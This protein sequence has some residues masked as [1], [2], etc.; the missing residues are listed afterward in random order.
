MPMCSVCHQADKTIKHYLL[1]CS[2]YER[3]WREL[4]RTV[5]LGLE[6]LS[7]LL[8]NAEYIKALFKF[9]NSTR[10]FKRTYGDLTVADNAM[11]TK[12]KGKKRRSRR[13]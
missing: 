10:Q 12:P 4:S 3:Q 13:G 11:S 6:A 7:K 5:D 2:A 1:Q 9:V 8:S